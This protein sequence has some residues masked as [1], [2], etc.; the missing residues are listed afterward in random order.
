MSK[1]GKVDTVRREYWSKE[2]VFF[3]VVNTVIYILLVIGDLIAYFMSTSK[4]YLVLGVCSIILLI[5]NILA[6]LLYMSICIKVPTNYYSRKQKYLTMLDFINV[7]HIMFIFALIVGIVSLFA[8]SV[9]I[10]GGFNG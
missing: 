8:S 9:I 6:G 1:I 3:T 4:V 10:N 5:T 7:S 2:G